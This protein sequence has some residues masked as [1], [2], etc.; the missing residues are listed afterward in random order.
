MDSVDYSLQN[1]QIGWNLRF[2]QHL[3][4]ATIGKKTGI[5]PIDVAQL[6]SQYW[7]E[8]GEDATYYIHIF[9]KIDFQ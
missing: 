4:Q 8:E 5:M 6:H 3:L 7:V 2:E 9:A 1:H